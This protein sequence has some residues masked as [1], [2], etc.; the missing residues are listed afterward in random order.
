MNTAPDRPPPRSTIA[1]AVVAACVICCAAPLLAVLAG[2]GAVFT[3]TA[4][5]V[6][7]LAVVAAL[8]FTAAFIPWRRRRTPR[9]HAQTTPVQLGMPN[10]ATRPSDAAD[11]TTATAST[12]IMPTTPG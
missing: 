2:I 6:P 5:W 11:P 7:A 1:T 12:A 3:L 4:I 8:A 9:R 10:T